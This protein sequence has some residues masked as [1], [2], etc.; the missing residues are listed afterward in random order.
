M[1]DVPLVYSMTSQSWDFFPPPSG[2]NSEMRPSSSMTYWNSCETVRQPSREQEILKSNKLQKLTKSEIWCLI[3]VFQASH[4]NQWVF[5]L[6]EV[7]FHGTCSL[8]WL[9]RGGS[10]SFFPSFFRFPRTTGNICNVIVSLTCFTCDAKG[11][12]IINFCWKLCQESK[13]TAEEQA[14]KGFCDAQVTPNLFVTRPQERC[15]K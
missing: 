13:K 11:T 8:C 15:L 2:G 3:H 4:N 12:N 14:Q 10:L 6:P 7:S 9:W 5:Q 1:V